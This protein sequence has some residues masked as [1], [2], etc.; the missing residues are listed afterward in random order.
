MPVQVSELV[1][2]RVILVRAYDEMTIPDAIASNQEIIQLMDEGHAATGSLVHIIADT[3]HMLR[4]PSPFEIRNAYVFLNHPARGEVVVGGIGNT[5]LIFLAK[6]V[7][8]MA[9]VPIEIFESTQQA[10]LVL[11]RRDPA[12]PDLLDAY[13][14]YLRRSGR[15]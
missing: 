14:Q 8:K 15:R 11:Q 12:L 4:Q 9:G 6:M 7:G 2:H 13:D 5:L 10:L 3:T 1:Q